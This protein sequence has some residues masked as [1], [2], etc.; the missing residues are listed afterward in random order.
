M[1]IECILSCVSWLQSEIISMW[2]QPCI[3]VIYRLVVS[4]ILINCKDSE[5]GRFESVKLWGCRSWLLCIMH[6]DLVDWGFEV[7]LSV[8]SESQGV[9]MYGLKLERTQ[10]KISVFHLDSARSRSWVVLRFRSSRLALTMRTADSLSGLHLINWVFKGS[11][12]HAWF[13]ALKSNAVE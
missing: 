1:C 11:K 10:V 3:K 4:D 13:R 6:V 5:F 9:S 12:D 8:W 2:V 7:D